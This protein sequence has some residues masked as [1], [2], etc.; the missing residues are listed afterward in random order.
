MN[1]GLPAKADRELYGEC[2]LIP[3]VG[4]TG[5]ICQNVCPAALNAST[6][7][8]A[9]GPRSPTPY[10][11]GRD[12]MCIKM[13][14]ARWLMVDGNQVRPKSRQRVCAPEECPPDIQRSSPNAGPDQPPSQRRGRRY[15][16]KP[17]GPF[18]NKRSGLPTGPDPGSTPR[19]SRGWP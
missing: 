18:Q 6:N 7:A 11:E 19:R 3:S 9:R 5:R 12:V 17:Y 15:P 1:K 13:P 14:L 10:G 16:D 8:W 2:P 4:L